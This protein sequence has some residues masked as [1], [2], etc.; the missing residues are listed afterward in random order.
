MLRRS[1]GTLIRKLVCVLLIMMLLAPTVPAT[2][3]AAATLPNIPTLSDTVSAR[4]K[5]SG[6]KI[7]HNIDST[8]TVS[9]PSILGAPTAAILSKVG[10]TGLTPFGIKAMAVWDAPN[11]VLLR[12]S[13]DSASW[14]PSD[15]Y[16][17]V[18]VI[19]GRP[20]VIAQGL[21][22]ENPSESQMQL[23]RDQITKTG[24]SLTLRTVEDEAVDLTESTDLSDFIFESRQ[25][26]SISQEVLDD[27]KSK[28]LISGNA[29]I[30]SAETAIRNIKSSSAKAPA[31][32]VV[33]STRDQFVNKFFRAMQI[34]QGPNVSELTQAP[35]VPQSLTL[36]QQAKTPITATTKTANI[37]PTQDL[38]KVR[39]NLV[40]LTHSNFQAAI[41]YGLG[42]VDEVSGV[43]SGQKISYYVI[44]NNKLVTSLVSNR[45]TVN[46]Q[47]SVTFG[48]SQQ[49]MPPTTLEAY[50]LDDAAYL[51]WGVSQD[52]TTRRL[53]AGYMVERKK[54]GETDYTLIT[55]DAPVV[56][57]L[58]DQGT[59]DKGQQVLSD[60]PS[61][62]T[63]KTVSNWDKIWYRVYAVDVFGRKSSYAKASE[64]S[65]SDAVEILVAKTIEPPT[66]AVTTPLLVLPQNKTTVVQTS[67]LPKPAA[68]RSTDPTKS[69][70]DITRADIHAAVEAGITEL[71]GVLVKQL[72][73]FDAE[74]ASRERT[75]ARIRDIQKKHRGDTGIAV[76][77]NHSLEPRAISSLTGVEL[78]LSDGPPQLAEDL[79]RYGIYRAVALGKN[80]YG[81]PEQ[82]TTIDLTGKLNDNLYTS[83]DNLHDPVIYYDTNIKPGHYYGYWVVAIDAW[84]NQSEWQDSPQIVG[85]PLETPPPVPNQVRAA[86]EL[87]PNVAERPD[88]KVP[89]FAQRLLL[90]HSPDEKG[91]SSSVG[92]LQD[93]TQSLSVNVP[94]SLDGQT[95]ETL[96]QHFIWANVHCVV[97]ADATQV[98]PNGKLTVQWEPYPNGDLIGYKVYRAYDPNATLNPR[99]EITS[100]EIQA[101][102]W[103]ELMPPQDINQAED[104]D[105]LSIFV[106]NRLED[107]VPLPVE[108]VYY[109]LVKLSLL[110][111]KKVARVYQQAG[112]ITLT[113]AQTDNP[114]IKGYRVYRAQ[115][116]REA[117]EGDNP[118]NIPNTE[119]HWAMLE[120]LVKGN[121][122]TEAVDQSKVHYYKYMIKAVDVWGQESGP[123][124][125]TQP[126]RVTTTIPPAVPV[127]LT[128]VEGPSQVAVRFK[129]VSDAVTYKLY[130][131]SVPNITTEDVGA[132]LDD[133]GETTT[134]GI[135]TTVTNLPEDKKLHIVQEIADR[136]GILATAPYA[137]LDFASA[138]EVTWTEV[139]SLETNFTANQAAIQHSTVLELVDDTAQYPHGY[140]YSVEAINNDDLSSGLSDPVSA[141]PQKSIGPVAPSLTTRSVSDGI[142]LTWAEYTK[143][144]AF[145]YV[146]YKAPTEDGPYHQLSPLLLNNQY[147]DSDVAPGRQ[148]WYRVVIIDEVGLLSAPSAPVAGSKGGTIFKPFKPLSTNSFSDVLDTRVTTRSTMAYLP[149]IKPPVLKEPIHLKLTV[150]ASNVT[151]NS[152][153]LSWP[154]VGAS[155]YEIYYHEPGEPPEFYEELDSSYTSYT[156]RDLVP[157]TTY[158]LYVEAYSDY[159][160]QVSNVVSIKTTEYLPSTID[161][162]SAEGDIYT[163]DNVRKAANISVFGKSTFDTVGDLI[164]EGLPP[165]PV[166]LDIQESE[167]GVLTRGSVSL[168]GTFNHSAEQSDL[169]LTSLS[170]VPNTEAIVTGSVSM[171]Q[172]WSMGA[173]RSITFSNAPLLPDGRFRLN[174]LDEI[175]IEEYKL[176]AD[177]ADLNFSG[178]NPGLSITSGTAMLSLGQITKSGRGIT[179]PVDGLTIDLAGKLNGYID[180]PQAESYHILQ[181]VVPRE[182][183]ILLA[184]GVI[185]LENGVVVQEESYVDGKVMLPFKQGEITSVVV[186][187]ND[188]EAVTDPTQQIREEAALYANIAMSALT[189]IQSKAGV[190]L[191]VKDKLVLDNSVSYILGNAQNNSGQSNQ[192]MRMGTTTMNLVDMGT[193]DF[194][195]HTW[196]GRGISPGLA[197]TGTLPSVLVY[198]CANKAMVQ[199]GESNTKGKS[200]I[201]VE[202]S[203]VRVSLPPVVLGTEPESAVSSVERGIAIVEGAITLP[204]DNVELQD[205]TGSVP[206]ELPIQ[207]GLSYNRNGLAGRVDTEGQTG[208]TLDAYL[209]PIYNTGVKAIIHSASIDIYANEADV[210]I[211]GDLPVPHL[212]K[213]LPFTAFTDPVTQKFICSFGRETNPPP[214]TTA[215]KQMII[216]GGRLQG[217]DVYLDGYISVNRPEQVL[218]EE[219]PFVELRILMGSKDHPEN[220]PDKKNYDRGQAATPTEA[221]VN[222]DFKMTTQGI[223]LKPQ[224][225]EDSADD[226]DDEGITG[227]DVLD[228]ALI[229]VMAVANNLPM[230]EAELNLDINVDLENSNLDVKINFIYEEFLA[231]DV[232][233]KYEDGE[234]YGHGYFWFVVGDEKAKAKDRPQVAGFV[235]ARVGKTEAGEDYWL[236]K[237]GYG[238]SDNKWQCRECKNVISMP[239]APAKC[240]YK[241]K[242]GDICE[243]DEFKA[244]KEPD[245]DYSDMTEE[246]IKEAKDAAKKK[247]EAKE[248]G[249]SDDAGLSIGP[250]HFR[251]IVGLAG[252]NMTPPKDPKDGSYRVPNGFA[253]DKMEDFYAW[254][255]TIDDSMFFVI[256]GS[257][258]YEYNGETLFD[259]DPIRLVVA[260][261]PS[262]EIE[263]SLKKSDELLGYG[264]IGYYHQDRRFLLGVGIPKIKIPVYNLDLIDLNF[265]VDVSPV[266]QHVAISYPLI[267]KIVGLKI[268]PVP[269]TAGGGFSFERDARDPQNVKYVIAMAAMFGIDTGE[270][271]V[272]DFLFVQARATITGDTEVTFVSGNFGFK[273]AVIVEASVVGGVKFRG[274]QHIVLRAGVYV[275]GEFE[276]LLLEELDADGIA[277]SEYWA[278][279]QAKVYYSVDIF[280]WEESGEFEW[281]LE[282]KID[283]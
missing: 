74:V 125:T 246:E 254:E 207:S 4:M 222:N 33:V 95:A 96:T 80:K 16:A 54:E 45:M 87:D 255:K 157:D 166:L 271:T 91:S 213:V 250:L 253:P 219:M 144:G 278:R 197:E 241:N 83:L 216:T 50:G 146:V 92:S 210:A 34:R 133:M 257:M 2:S 20:E 76:L 239:T 32:P 21:G 112:T 88:K 170:L 60:P 276:K 191:S 137:R 58:I 123:A 281:V 283:L 138:S 40:A 118:H 176:R 35:V 164:I 215:E 97:Q 93:L 199:F 202:G 135:A 209:N 264:R 115:Y 98:R 163:I 178:A 183:D 230:K 258:S 99:S 15:G 189:S 19:D 265:L 10:S 224:P 262:I 270:L 46:P 41:A 82:V 27:L 39:S 114:Q 160:D 185:T 134:A 263:V 31:D 184:E 145:G 143:P 23:I 77:F 43:K 162:Y 128:P 56:V 73:E 140:L 113:W 79:Y 102:T 30:T 78:G 25:M 168:K 109:Y 208:L 51:R 220:A 245:P 70:S 218:L 130:R 159:G 273:I 65:T 234:F 49:I 107:S 188:Q 38:L 259:L 174:G 121:T 249:E 148:Y 116:P 129:P 7:S 267:A 120:Q 177:T 175:W 90:A 42:Y 248:R 61:Y 243:N 106:T 161:V 153:T 252:Y 221:T 156:V 66:P 151:T 55:P 136:F 256:E 251:Y 217:N 150:T 57:G 147:V 277:L 86:F 186:T 6:V 228:V 247:E 59:N 261:G 24:K 1:L 179:V 37:D 155:V 22:A 226:S 204:P 158:F 201:Q 119:L 26:A 232:V 195:I 48:Q 203:E 268:G 94:S 111:E 5:V 108:G 235:Q 282:K 100:Q 52:E 198:E 260:S 171:P 212:E 68:P 13:P 214:A 274:K 18:R 169:M 187:P 85:Y 131:A 244:Y 29:S 190:A 181:L 279:G 266:R 275:K 11:R 194:N 205:D 223:A 75:D 3:S 242:K 280:I 110:P 227:Q 272:A 67:L 9:A 126:A 105:P 104:A 47:I 84:G 152:I 269:I 165:I 237:F 63:D 69:S 103:T 81:N 229:G 124:Y 89:G 236:F 196:N 173:T 132:I 28:N 240:P 238:L 211:R 64:K 142:S 193:I 200:L 182:V 72:V 14:I 117:V 231:I 141:E 122:Y 149:I 8:V 225:T 172:V 101:M 17:L 167:D 36:L 233:A 62:Y 180:I 127:L 12:W 44:P 71:N 206:F 192:V 139:A 154:N 53:V